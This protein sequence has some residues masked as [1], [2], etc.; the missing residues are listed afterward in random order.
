MNE[1]VIAADSPTAPDVAALLA[2]HLAFARDTSP[3][4]D[5]HALDADGLQSET[6]SFFSVRSGGELLGIGA[7]KQLAAGHVEIKSMHTAQGARG[8]GVGRAM[9]A[10]L[11]GV[12]C[13]RGCGRVSLETGSVEEFAA[14]RA[15]YA[16]A[17]FVPC[18]P[19]ADYG[20]SRH[21]TFMTLELGAGP[22]AQS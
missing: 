10:H 16:A 18:E 15:L 22:P 12:A 20:S 13:S 14:A 21:S 7:L 5:V 19:F 2:R 1:L 17:G 8:R 6:V 9:L 4:E 3:P 11:L